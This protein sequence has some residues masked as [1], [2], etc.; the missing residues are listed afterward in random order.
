MPQLV[1]G[2]WVKGDIAASE[3]PRYADALMNACARVTE[4]VHGRAPAQVG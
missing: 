3:V 2:E 4:L 1:K